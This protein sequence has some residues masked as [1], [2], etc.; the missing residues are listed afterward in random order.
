M[1][2]CEEQTDA[3]GSV[4]SPVRWGLATEMVVP[5]TD[6]LFVLDEPSWTAHPDG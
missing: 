1:A 6:G 4:A 3:D 2:G 5:D